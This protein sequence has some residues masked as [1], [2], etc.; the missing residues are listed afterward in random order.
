ME[1][2]QAYI[3]RIK[4]VNR[5]HQRL[6][7]AVDKSLSTMLAGQA[8]LVR[9]I[10][11]DYDSENWA[12]YLRELWFPVEI[13]ASNI[14]VVEHPARAQFLPGQLLSIISP[15]GQ[16]FRFRQKLRNILLIAYHT[17]PA[18][19]LLMLPPLL[20]KQVSITLVLM[21]SAREYETNHLPEE[22]E[23]IQAEDNLTWPDM[24]M[25]LGWADQAFV[26][27]GPGDEM[28]Y[29]N[30]ILQLMRERRSDIP[31]NYVFGVLQRALPCGVGACH[32]C[33]LKLRGSLKLPC[34]EG[35]AFDLTDLYMN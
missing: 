29:F 26:L 31:S 10:D 21:G 30:E 11:K 24:V 17:T 35:P 3:E 13:L 6:E 18:A 2:T 4:R 20:A 27:V 14:I 34:I 12:P 25:T 33:M 5:G 28:A 19:L 23:V 8:M 22:L 1:E 7:L 9:Q 16:P 15:V 32:A